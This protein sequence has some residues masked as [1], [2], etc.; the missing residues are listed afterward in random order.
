MALNLHIGA[1]G[2]QIP[3]FR[4]VDL[5]PQDP[6]DM[7]GHAGRLPVYDASVDV[8]F[9][10]ALFE[11]LFVAHQV[12]VLREWSRVLK[13]DGVMI[14]TGIPNFRAIAQAY[15]EGKTGL[16]GPKFD[17]YHV[18]RYTHGHPEDVTKYPWSRWDPT[19]HPN[20]APPGWLPQLHKSLFDAPTLSGLLNSAGLPYY[21]VF[22]YAFPSERLPLNLGFVAS[23]GRPTVVDNDIA[24]VPLSDFLI[25]KASV[26]V[27]EPKP[28]DFDDLVTLA[29][30]S[31]AETPLGK[32]LLLRLIRTA[33]SHPALLHFARSARKRLREP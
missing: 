7:R 2:M 3:G 9:S 11:H 32:R 30:K 15:L 18:Y 16:V 25:D 4:A 23:M 21:T 1:G 19:R 26:A 33:R 28:D 10:N 6:Q 20:S 8:L 13:P 14:A 29:N 5:Q 27:H 17:L 12:T 22:E 31:G 24:L